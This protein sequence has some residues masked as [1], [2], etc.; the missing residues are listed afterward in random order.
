MARAGL[1]VGPVPSDIKRL[2]GAKNA[3]RVRIGDYRAIY[4]IH[5]EVVTVVVFRVAHRRE[6][7]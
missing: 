6:V 4:E 5:D 2:A 7:Y 1:T 3:W